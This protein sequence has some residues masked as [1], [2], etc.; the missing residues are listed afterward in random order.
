MY[1][2][3]SYIFE[4]PERALLDPVSGRVV[5]RGILKLFFKLTQMER[6]LLLR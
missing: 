3:M 4:H 5:G 1:I 2:T 6:K